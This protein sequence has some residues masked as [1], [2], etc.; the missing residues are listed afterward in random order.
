MGF[1]PIESISRLRCCVKRKST[2]FALGCR[3]LVGWAGGAA[4]AGGAE[5]AAFGA[6][7]HDFRVAFEGFTHGGQGGAGAEGFSHAV[8][9]AQMCDRS[10]F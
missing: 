5:F 6:V 9:L 3:E 4:L 10:K 2:S 1:S 8:I 7:G